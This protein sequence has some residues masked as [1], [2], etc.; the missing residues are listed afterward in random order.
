MSKDRKKNTVGLTKRRLKSPKFL[1][2]SSAILS[3]LTNAFV[4]TTLIIGG[5]DF[6]NWII[7]LGLLVL[8][9]VFFMLAMASNFRFRYAFA[10]PILYII[11]VLG[12]AVWTFLSDGIIKESVRYSQFAMYAWLALHVL[13]CFAILFASL[14]GAKLG[15][16]GNRFVGMASILFVLLLAGSGA[17]GYCL[18]SDGV[19]GQGSA[20]KIRTLEYVYVD[21]MDYY[22][23]T[24]VMNGRGDTVIVPKEFNGKKVGSLNCAVL[25]DVAIKNVYLED[26]SIHLLNVENL[27]DAQ[28][29]D[30]KIYVEKAQCNAFRETCF[31]SAYQNNNEGYIRIANAVVP[32]NMP[33]G[34]VFVTFSYDMDA[35][36]AVKG[37]TLEVWYGKKGDA[38][39]LSS[40]VGGDEYLSKKDVNNLEDVYWAYDNLDKRI[41]KD[42]AYRSQSVIDCAVTGNMQNVAVEFEP[43]YEVEICE[44]NDELYEVE[45][46]FK[47]QTYA[48]QQRNYVLT[49]DGADKYLSTVQGRDGFSLNWVYGVG[50]KPLNDSL[51]NVI[52]DKMTL[53]PLW[54]LNL[55]TIELCETNA[56]AGGATYGDVV[57]F[58]ALGIAPISTVDIRYQW[59][60]GDEV[61][62]DTANWTDDCI[63]PSEG[64]VYELTVEAYSDTLTSLTSTTSTSISMDVRKKE[65][66]FQWTLPEDNIYSASD[67]YIACDYETS[68]VING[69]MIDFAVSLVSVRDAGTYQSAVSLYGMC[70]ELYVI[71]TD[72]NAV[73]YVVLPYEVEASW[74]GESFIYN[75]QVQQPTAMA[76]GLG[77]DGALELTV[78]G[79][80]RNASDSAYTAIATTDNTNYTITNP[81]MQFTIAKAEL[82]VLWGETAL[83]YKGKVQAP[84]V[85]AI[86]LGDDGEIPVTVTGGQRN[87]GDTVHTASVTTSN[88]NYTIT[89]PTIQFTISKAELALSWGNTS[90]VYNAKEQTPTVT[91]MGLGDDGA[92]KLTVT[93]AQRNAG[94]TVHTASVTIDNANYIIT[95]PTKQFTIAKAEI[96]VVWKNVSLIYNATAQKPT[97]TAMGVGNDGA[98]AVTV[99]GEKTLAGAYTAIASINNANYKLRNANASF[100]INKRGITVTWDKNSF[101]YDGLAHRPQIKDVT[102]AIDSEKSV[103]LTAMTCVGEALTSAGNGSVTAVLGSDN[104]S[105]NYYIVS[106]ATHT[107]TVVAKTITVSATSTTFTYNGQPKTP[108]FSASDKSVELNVVYYKEDGTLL[109]GEPTEIGSYYA[110][111]TTK[112]SNYAIAGGEKIVDFTIVAPGVGTL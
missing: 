19:Y 41:F 60:R 93:G 75:A 15:K 53:Y 110:V 68:D 22:R 43:L 107:Y 97:A 102:N 28:T 85:I 104:V 111:I 45:D 46:S 65:L 58:S 9:L 63:Y 36:N 67:K 66:N 92:L 100:T 51:K 83:V 96:S 74:A 1:I 49:K 11:F 76:M 71:P 7:P 39:Q 57:E 59:K 48:D 23:V 78:L 40:L 25:E 16:K 13:S 89:N 98:L 79:G 80:Q 38:L 12:L 112:S 62:S 91:A 10:L 35:L 94:D 101:V 109:S 70:N 99:T 8:D 30:R 69:D 32:G 24:N 73:T 61:V 108:S 47:Y 90:L 52:Y 95:N 5:Y 18:Y 33:A 54:S 106:G 3:I 2:A 4:L 88:E 103:V 6:V 21:E 72:D 34:E 105:K 56:I 37:E 44:D 31:A 86:G 50:K 84:E 42:L 64:G 87:A 14:R 82:E 81:T 26:T 55:P 17:Y 20:G 29:E 27:V 77:D